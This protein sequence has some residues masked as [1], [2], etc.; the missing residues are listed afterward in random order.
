MP[1]TTRLLPV[2]RFLPFVLRLH[3]LFFCSPHLAAWLGDFREIEREHNMQANQPAAGNAGIASRLAI[4]HLCPGLPEPGRCGI[5]HHDLQSEM[6][7]VRSQIRSALVFPMRARVSA[8][9]SDVRR[10]HQEQL[11]VGVDRQRGV[12]VTSS[13]RFGL[14]ALLALSRL[15]SAACYSRHA[16]CR[17][18]ALSVS[19]QV[20]FER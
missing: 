12:G 8:H 3:G 14:V 2:P 4:E 19:H 16:C 7:I 5:T 13:G 6:S 9:M 15:G 18:S 10:T 17:S 11:L 1:V 20:R